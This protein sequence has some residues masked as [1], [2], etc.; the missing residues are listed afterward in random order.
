MLYF[1]FTPDTGQVSKICGKVRGFHGRWD[2]IDIIASD[3]T[4][5]VLNILRVRSGNL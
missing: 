4:V 5:R 2:G 3:V 1:G